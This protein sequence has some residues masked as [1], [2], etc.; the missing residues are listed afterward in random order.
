MPWQRCTPALPNPTPAK[1]LARCIWERASTSSALKTDLGW[2]LKNHEKGK[3]WFGGNSLYCNLFLFLWQLLSTDINKNKNIF[4][5]TW[6]I[7]I[8]PQKFAIK[9]NVYGFLCFSWLPF[10]SHTHIPQLMLYSS[11]KNLFNVK[12]QYPGSSSPLEVLGQSS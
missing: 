1:V 10:Y 2:Y 4:M 9:R 11:S 8:C 12:E 7:I 6:E 5:K 3:N